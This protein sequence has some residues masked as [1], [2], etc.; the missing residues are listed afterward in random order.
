MMALDNL[1][2]FVCHKTHLTI[3]RQLNGIIKKSQFLDC[4]K[5]MNVSKTEKQ[6][7]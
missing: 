2:G 4:L 7:H 6:K 5:L 3:S 1:E